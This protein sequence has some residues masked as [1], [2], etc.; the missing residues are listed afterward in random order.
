MQALFN[1]P[2]EII[3][4]P[5]QTITTQVINIDIVVDYPEAKRVQAQTKELGVITLWEGTAYDT[6]GQWT[7]TDV[8]NR[9][10]ELYS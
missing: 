9:V 1:A 6:I 7:D 5:Q 8:I 2:K 4:I 10:I 3:T